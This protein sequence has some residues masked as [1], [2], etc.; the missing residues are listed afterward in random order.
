MGSKLT[1]IAERKGEVGLMGENKNDDLVDRGGDSGGEER[2]DKGDEGDDGD[3]GLFGAGISEL[4]DCCL[5]FFND[6]KIESRPSSSTRASPM[7]SLVF[8]L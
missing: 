1:E 8:K 4:D 3:A 7:D 5:N 6:S 2:Y